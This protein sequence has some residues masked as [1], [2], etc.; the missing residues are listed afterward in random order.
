MPMPRRQFLTQSTSLATALSASLMAAPRAM[1]A[2][3]APT[4][5]QKLT[6]TTPMAPPEWAL[7]Q[8]AVL[9]AHTDACE[10]FFRRYYD[11]NGFLLARERWGGDDGPDDAIENVNDWPQLYALG[12]DER[13]R[14]LYEHA[15]EGHVRQYTLAKTT[16]VPFAREGMY[17][18]EF[19]V[20]MDWQHN[21]EGLTV[22]NNMG[23]GNPY[24]QAYRNRVRR[25]AGFYTGEDPSAP[26]YDKQHKI[27]KSMFNGSRGPLMRKA[28]A[29]DWAGDPVELAGVDQNALLHGEHDYDQMLAHFK[30]YTD[31]TGDTPLNLE[32]TG[33]AFNAYMLAGEE[34]YRAWMLEYVDAWV[35]R[36][37]A[38]N[39]IIP[40]NIGYDGKIGGE[41][42]GKWYGGV[43][44][45]A[46]SPVVPQTGQRQDRNRIGFTLSAF[47]NAYVISGGNDKYLDVWRK[48]TDRINAQAKTVNGKLSAPRMYGDN[49]WY[50]F[51]PGKW[52]LGAQDI[53]YL[54][55]KPADRARMPDH[56]WISYLE[57]KNPTYPVQALRLALERIRNAHAALLSDQSTPDTRF[58]DTVMDQNPANIAALVEL[59]QG[60]IYVGRPGWSRYSPNVGGAFQFVRLRYFDPLNRRPGLPEGVSA[61]VEGI[62][63]DETVVTLVN[64]NQSANRTVTLQGGAYGEHQILS[65]TLD[66]KAVPVNG[67]VVEVQLAPG[68]GAKL[69][70]KMQRF[71][72]APRLDFPWAAPIMDS[73]EGLRTMTAEERD[74]ML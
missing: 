44:G 11:A 15:Y 28:T 50:S 32:S 61:L 18:R 29:L 17:F 7:L 23:L 52:L 26:N 62:T 55:M 42:G 33:L 64:T 4:A 47:M 56:P 14:T 1:A 34:K 21:G 46:F 66:G 43:Y 13:I 69:V 72:N 40:T 19:P 53:Y 16:Q 12:A 38:N 74:A 70:L 45:W 35:E 8:R 10:A 31:T 27:I 68:A 57:G 39:D 63:A 54:T 24:S 51:Q 25:F 9:A 73:T 2:P 36:A 67:R 22:F 59:M 60:G 41:A 71:A 48:M 58:A 20:M 3:A 49:G 5:A 30:D 6:I 37:R 65:V